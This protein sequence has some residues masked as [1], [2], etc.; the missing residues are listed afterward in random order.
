M[1]CRHL[2]VNHSLVTSCHEDLEIMVHIS[3]WDICDSLDVMSVYRTVR[4]STPRPV[5]GVFFY[6][7][8][9]RL[10][11]H[12]EVEVLLSPTNQQKTFW[13]LFHSAWGM[14]F[15]PWR[16][17]PF[18]LCTGR[19]LW[20]GYPF[21]PQ[22]FLLS[23]RFKK[24]FQVCFFPSIYP[25]FLLDVEIRTSWIILAKIYSKRMSFLFSESQ[26]SV[27]KMGGNNKFNIQWRGRTVGSVNP[28]IT[29]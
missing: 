2:R 20:D 12:H 16:I 17:S 14:T 10:R 6:Y 11:P 8:F 3:S 7:F 23:Q 5:L 19:L 29:Q 22:A 25:A 13:F 26:V 9:P 15:F 1:Q 21:S 28:L 18:Q 24:S 4:W 27:Y